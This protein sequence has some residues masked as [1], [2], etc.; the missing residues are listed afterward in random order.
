MSAHTPGP[1]WVCNDE[2]V[3]SQDGDIAEIF[4]PK[5]K[6]LEANALL[7]AA[8]PDLLAALIKILERYTA[9]AN[10]GDVGFW[11]CELEPQV[12]ASRAAIAKAIGETLKQA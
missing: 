7:I 8:A 10:S 5:G 9:L 1:W 6:V 3:L 4:S 12:I 2:L 11:D